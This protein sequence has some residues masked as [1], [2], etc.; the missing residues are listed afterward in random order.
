MSFCPRDIGIHAGNSGAE[1]AG[2]YRRRERSEVDP[3]PT[4]CCQQ[5]FQLLNQEDKEHEKA[6]S[7]REETNDRSDGWR[8]S[9][10][11]ER[12]NNTNRQNADVRCLTR[13]NSI[14]NG[15]EFAVMTQVACAFRR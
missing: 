7:L 4:A 3:R 2:L 6:R 11:G 12:S 13:P 15:R 1:P 14:L 10:P 9:E 5:H 8:S